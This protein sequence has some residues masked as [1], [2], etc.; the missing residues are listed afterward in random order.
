[1]KAQATLTRVKQLVL[2]S[3]MACLPSALRADGLPFNKDRSG[4][5]AHVVNLKLTP[6]QQI[7]V[8]RTRVLTLTKTQRERLLRQAKG[9]PTEL[10]VLTNRYDDCTCQMASIAVWFKPG[11]VVVPVSYLPDAPMSKEA[12]EDVGGPAA[13]VDLVIDENLCLWVQGRA[14][15]EQGLKSVLL[16]WQRDPSEKK[17]LN[18]EGRL[19]I[20]LDTPP[21]TDVVNEAQLKRMI[22]RIRAF[23]SEHQIDLFVSGFR[24]EGH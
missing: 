13:P 20:Y 15:T 19:W 1:M 16:R 14:A 17:R 22:S 7:Q 12:L 23:T 4:L 18:E 8:S 5:E 3:L 24:A 21:M 10:Q 2:A 6:K 9:C 11:E